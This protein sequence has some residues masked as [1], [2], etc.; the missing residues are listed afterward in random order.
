LFVRFLSSRLSIL[1]L[2][3][4]G[5][6]ALSAVPARAL[7]PEFGLP[8]GSEIVEV[9]TNRGTICLELLRDGAPITVWNFVN[10]VSQG[11][12][13]GTIIHRSVPGF[14]IQGG[15]FATD[16]DTVTPIPID[17]TITNEPCTQVGGTGICAVRGNIRGTVAMARV[18]G[19]INSAT[20]QYFINLADN[21][22]SLDA[23]DEGFTV[24]ANV[25]GAGMTVADDVASLPT[26]DAN[27]S[28]WIAPPVGGVLGELPI[29]NVVPFFPTAFGCWD[30]SDLALVVSPLS[31]T[32]PLPDPFFGTAFYPLSGG[33]GV[34][35]PR[36]SFVEDPGPPSCT[37]FDLLATGVVGLATPT[38]R[39]DPATGDFLQYEFSCEQTVE[40]VIQRDLWR[41]D[42]GARAVSEMVVIE[43][44]TYQ[45]VPEP[46]IG[47]LLGSGVISLLLS[48]RR[49]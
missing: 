12:Y 14:V 5:V 30:P 29:Q 47:L 17:G 46:S 32:F 15:A 48:I 24:F 34:Q 26:G 41:D 20:S 23:A 19:Q 7:C 10:Y 13:D 42:L 8:S 25:L 35:I 36:F 43:N 40:A 37:D 45:P 11:D 31:H 4:L 49:F 27:E 28:W 21:R 3:S 44:A 22:A 38:I 33:C 39:I 18:G 2:V 6:I 16:A 1:C 9:E